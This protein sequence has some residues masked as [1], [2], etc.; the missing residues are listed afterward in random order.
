MASN[1]IHFPQDVVIRH[2]RRVAEQRLQMLEEWMSDDGTELRHD[3]RRAGAA[4]ALPDAR[5][6]LAKAQRAEAALDRGIYTPGLN[7]LSYDGV[8]YYADAGRA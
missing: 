3:I 7:K 8:V 4:A 1:I 5:I 2:A 6:T